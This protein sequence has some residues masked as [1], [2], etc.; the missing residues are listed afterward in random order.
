MPKRRLV[1]RFRPC[2]LLYRL[3]VP[4]VFTRC[5]C[6]GVAGDVVAAA[7]QLDRAGRR[8]GARGGA[9]GHRYEGGAGGGW[10]HRQ[11]GKVPRGV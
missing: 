5:W 1:C 4:R 6:V 2:S 10:R 9:V 8:R 11:A 7:R 3:W